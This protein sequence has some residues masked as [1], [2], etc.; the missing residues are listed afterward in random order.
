MK[1]PAI[2]MNTKMLNALLLFSRKRNNEM[3]WNIRRLV[4]LHISWF[5]SCMEAF[6]DTLLIVCNGFKYGCIYKQVITVYIDFKKQSICNLLFN[7]YK[8]FA[9]GKTKWCY[10]T[11]TH[12]V[13]N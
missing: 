4:L 2:R 3:S 5:L 1:T 11:K 9:W 12:Y 10:D 13:F 6:K 7:I 8:I